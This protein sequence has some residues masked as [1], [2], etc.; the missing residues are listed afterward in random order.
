M[1]FFAASWIVV[2]FANSGVITGGL[3]IILGAGILNAGAG[4]ENLDL[5]PRVC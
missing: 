3:M 2:M 4:D 1:L 5:V